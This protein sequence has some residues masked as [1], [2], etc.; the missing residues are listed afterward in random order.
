M[1]VFKWKVFKE[2]T[3]TLLP[4]FLKFLKELPKRKKVAS[5]LFYSFPAF[6]N[7]ASQIWFQM[8]RKDFK[9]KLKYIKDVV[10]IERSL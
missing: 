10:A 2:F 7:M 5:T 1:H 3:L 4:N 9:G 8:A 6:A